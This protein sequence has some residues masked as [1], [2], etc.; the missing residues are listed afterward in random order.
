MRGKRY[1][2]V[3]GAIERSNDLAADRLAK[4]RY[5]DAQRAARRGAG[6]ICRGGYDDA[7]N[8]HGLAAMARKFEQQRENDNG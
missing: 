7:C 2:G 5:D 3:L 8:V 4:L 6:C 1:F